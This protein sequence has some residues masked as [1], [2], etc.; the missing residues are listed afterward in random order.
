MWPSLWGAVAAKLWL[1]LRLKG[2][3]EERAGLAAGL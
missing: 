1:L 2:V 3:T